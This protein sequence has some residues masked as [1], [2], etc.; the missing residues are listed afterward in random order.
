MEHVKSL[1]DSLCDVSHAISETRLVLNL[2]RGLNP[3]FSITADHI[4]HT[5]QFPSFGKARSMLTLK[6]SMLANET[7]VVSEMTLTATAS[8]LPCPPDG[9]TGSLGTHDGGC[10]G[11]GGD[12]G[13]GGRNNCGHGRNGRGG[14]G[15]CSDDTNSTHPSFTPHGPLFCFNPYT[16]AAPAW[17]DSSHDDA[18]LLGHAPSMYQSAYNT[19][20]A[21]L[22]M[23]ATPP[24]VSAQWDQSALIA[25]LNN[26]APLS[27]AG[28]VID[29]SATS[30]MSSDNGIVPPL[31]PLPYPMYITV[32]NGAHVLVCFYSNMHLCLPSSNFVLKSV[33]RVP[34]LIQIPI[35]VHQ[36]TCDN[37][38]SIEFDPLGFSVKDL[39]T[40]REIIHYNSLSDLCTIPPAPVTPS[41][42]AFISSAAP[43]PIWHTH[44]GHPSPIV[45]NKL[46]S[47]SSIVCNK[48]AH[49]MCHACQLGKH[50]WLP[51]NS[52]VSSSTCP[53]ELLH[54]D[55]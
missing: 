55:V 26:M 48:S 24:S 44:L 22:Q 2:I 31:L 6:E 3:K 5:I 18:G 13:H 47:S 33:L 12:H 34:S 45:L 17:H 23:P 19:S 8:M 1:A 39:K 16:Q 9:C 43:T 41:R 30:H 28:W 38:V 11:G 54:C 36:F 32:G 25:A 15:G 49:R 50:V 21:P 27:Q 51:F 52:S 7:K 40:Q 42:Q 46:Q 4:V 35:S 14:G 37:V 29:S 53:F 10:V 20:F